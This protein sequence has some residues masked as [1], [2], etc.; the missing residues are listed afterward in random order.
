MFKTTNASPPAKLAAVNVVPLV[1]AFEETVAW[2]GAAASH[3]QTPAVAD[4]KIA[5]VFGCRSNP[6]EPANPFLITHDPQPI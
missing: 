2:I 5:V 3:H 4:E 6:C 1:A